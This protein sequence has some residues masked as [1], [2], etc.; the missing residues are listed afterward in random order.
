MKKERITKKEFEELTGENPEDILGN[1]WENIVEEL[2]EIKIQ[3]MF[4]KEWRDFYKKPGA[5]M[6]CKSP[7]WLRGGCP[8]CGYKKWEVTGDGWA[9]CQGCSKGY[10]TDFPFTS[11]LLE[12][13]DFS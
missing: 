10:K 12:E 13:L 2:E 6:I 8:I 5:I 11:Q 1:D 7:N 4:G 3:E 9:Y